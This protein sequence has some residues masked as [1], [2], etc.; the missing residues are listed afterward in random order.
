[1]KL[2]FEQQILRL[3][4]LVDATKEVIPTADQR[5]LL[6][7]LILEELRAIRSMLSKE[8]HL[9]QPQNGIQATKLDRDVIDRN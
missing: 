3:R 4:Q 2:T 8:Y 7:I 6:L 5:D 9:G 1:M